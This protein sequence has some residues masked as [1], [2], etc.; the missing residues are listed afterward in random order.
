[1]IST[2]CKF[3]V[4]IKVSN[5]KTGG[6]NIDIILTESLIDVRNKSKLCLPEGS[7]VHILGSS[8]TQ[9]LV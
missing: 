4:D 2:V 5:N 7:F 9:E 1:M 3:G 8:Q 6:Q